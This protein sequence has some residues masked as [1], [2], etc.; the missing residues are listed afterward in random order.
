MRRIG[1]AVA[2]ACVAAVAIAGVRL[3]GADGHGNGNGQEASGFAQSTGERAA[4]TERTLRGS[5]VFSATGFN[6]VG[7]VQQPK[8]IVEVIVFH[9]DGTLDVPAATVSLNGV[10][11][12]SLHSSGTY[13]VENNCSGTI[14]F[15]GP[16]YDMFLSKH[17]DH[18][19]MIQTNPNTVFQGLATRT[20]RTVR[21]FSQDQ[22]TR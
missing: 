21:E 14:A 13:T 6:I 8:A 7:G 12:R 10:I 5:Y 20:S 4:C 15:N 2:M 11:I 22:R 16:T 1:W 17:G 18:I 3:V 19:S 9:G